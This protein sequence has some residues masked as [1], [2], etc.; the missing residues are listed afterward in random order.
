MVQDKKLERLRKELALGE[1][2]VKQ[3]QE[4]ADIEVQKSQLRRKLVLLK[5]P[6][7]VALARKF[8]AGFKSTAKTIGRSL[9]KQGKLI[10]AQQERDRRLDV[11]REKQLVKV[12]KSR[13][14]KKLKSVSNI[15]LSIG[16][17][18]ITIKQLKKKA[19]LKTPK[20]EK[21]KLKSQDNF[22]LLGGFDF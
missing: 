4:R 8:K 17:K 10:S 22:D 13:K 14:R 20:R 7:K 6:K 16:G 11:A 12:P 21:R 19:R 18:T 1:A 2:Q 3:E 9:L 15:N 5:N